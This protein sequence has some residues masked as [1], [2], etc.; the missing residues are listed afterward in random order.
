MFKILRLTRSIRLLGLIP[1]II[2]CCMDFE[3]WLYIGCMLRFTLGILGA[4][5]LLGALDSDGV[6]WMIT[7]IGG[8]L[9]YL[10]TIRSGPLDLF[11]IPH[12]NYPVVMDGWTKINVRI[13]SVVAFILGFKDTYQH[14]SM[15]DQ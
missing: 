14:R 5:L 6:G 4:Y 9:V 3:G 12:F 15:E 13:I 2:G 11:V 10:F 7:F 8:L 1:L